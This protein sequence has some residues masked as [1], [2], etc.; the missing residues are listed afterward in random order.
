MLARK[1]VGLP[2]GARYLLPMTRPSYTPDRSIPLRPITPEESRASGFPP[3]TEVTETIT[4][5][6]LQASGAM[7]FTDDRGLPALRPTA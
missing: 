1:R 5:D 7:H 3:G 4:S 2:C 6:E